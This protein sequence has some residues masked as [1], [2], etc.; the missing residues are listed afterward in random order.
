MATTWTNPIAPG[1]PIRAANIQELI[2]AINTDRQAAGLPPYGWTDPIILPGVPIAALDFQEMRQAIQ[3]LWNSAD[4]GALPA[5]PCGVPGGESVDTAPTPVRAAHVLALRYWVNSY[6]GIDYLANIIYGVNA[7]SYYPTAPNQ[8]LVTQGWIDYVNQALPQHINPLPGLTPPAVRCE[9]ITAGMSLSSAEMSYF[10][11]A[12]SLYAQQSPS[13]NVYAIMGQQFYTASG[14]NADIPDPTDSF[15]NDYITEFESLVAQAATFFS[16]PQNGGVTNFLI[17][18]ETNGPDTPLSSLNFASLL[19][20]TCLAKPDGVNYW[21]GGIFSASTGL[22]ID[23]AEMEY[24]NEVFSYLAQYASGWAPNWAGLNVH[25]DYGRPQGQAFS[26]MELFQNFGF[27]LIV[28]EWGITNQEYGIDHTSIGNLFQQIVLNM[29]Q[30]M[31]YFSHHTVVDD[32]G[33]WGIVQD[34][35]AL[36]PSGPPG[37]FIYNYDQPLKSAYVGLFTAP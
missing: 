16:Q 24:I 13:I 30:A 7:H 12:F 18:N 15:T 27:P 2:T 10:A 19:Y 5:W 17:W 37:I 3:D 1:D 20:Q 11:Q 34:T 25:I 28:G 9:L 23:P 33:T 26:I 36:P 6:E 31:F 21:W 8:P 14:A 32:Q 29:P 35:D 4:L 22:T